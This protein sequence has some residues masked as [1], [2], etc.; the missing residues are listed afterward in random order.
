MLGARLDKTFGLLDIYV[1]IKL[2]AEV[3]TLDVD[4]E[5]LETVFVSKREYKA[6]RGELHCGGVSLIEIYS[7]FLGKTLCNKVSFV[8]V[9]VA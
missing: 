1:F 5:K 2:A 8:F 4:L 7:G 3:F 9:D 6:D